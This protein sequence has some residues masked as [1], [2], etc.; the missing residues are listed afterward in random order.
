[1]VG[2]GVVGA[3]V[4]G[5]GVVGAGV[6]GAGVV[7]AGVVGAGVVGAG[8]V[9]AGVVGAG[10]VGAGVV[11]AGVVGAGVVGAGVV[12]AGVVGAGV[13][14]AGVVGAGVVGAGVVGAGVVGAGV[15]CISFLDILFGSCRSCSSQMPLESP[16]IKWAD[17]SFFSAFVEWMTF[18]G[19][20]KPSP[21]KRV[22]LLQLMSFVA[23]LLYV[24]HEFNLVRILSFV[25]LILSQA[26]H[27][28]DPSSCMT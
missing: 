10:V 20:N 13:V 6:V 9:G 5:A 22:Y 8:V 4:V 15:S 2:A 21:G 18:L 23:I 12:G 24:V 19:R 28:F 11:G 3:G 26:S 7:G 25:N 27:S 17:F 14:G 16:K 1:V